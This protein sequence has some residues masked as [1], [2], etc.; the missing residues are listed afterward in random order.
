[1]PACA[2]RQIQI[3]I[4]PKRLAAY[5]V[6]V[7][8]VMDAIRQANQDVPAGRISNPRNDTLVRVEGK[9]RDVP[10]VQRHHR[11]APRRAASAS[12]RSA[13]PAVGDSPVY[14]GQVATVVDGEQEATSAG[15]H[16]GQRALSVQIYKIQDANIVETGEA[17]KKP[18]RTSCRACRPASRSR[19]STRTR[20][21]SSDRSTA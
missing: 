12:A 21:G 19:R 14:L 5:G 10:R 2:A 6:G 13:R 7:D 3:Q 20:T 4:D 18:S 8:Q 11:R 16:D 17:V 9:L 1:M 15:R